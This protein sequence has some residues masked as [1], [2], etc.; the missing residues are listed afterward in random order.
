MS[1]E[2]YNDLVTAA[3]SL[4]EEARKAIVKRRDK[5]AA[6]L[7][8]KAAEI[9]RSLDEIRDSES[10]DKTMDMLKRKKDSCK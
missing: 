7:L 10:F 2:L 1:P 6:M 5:H 9:R 8:A 3:N 4:E